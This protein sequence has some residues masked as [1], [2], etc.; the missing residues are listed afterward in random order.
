MRTI[1]RA[2]V[3]ALASCLALTTL[4]T[5]KGFT[6]QSVEKEISRQFPRIK[7]LSTNELASLLQSPN[8]VLLDVRQP[9]EF[10]V[11]HLPGAQRVT[12]LSQTDDCE[13]HPSQLQLRNKTVVF[14]CSVG[15]RSSQIAEALDTELKNMGVS[16]VYNLQGGIFAWHNEKRALVNQSGATDFVHPFDSHYGKLLLRQN[17]VSTTLR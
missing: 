2:F 7:Q 12:P 9:Q 4:Y 14:Y 1:F 6:L 10:A 15:Y 3:A 16:A 13:F 5:D 17:L 11:S 8:L